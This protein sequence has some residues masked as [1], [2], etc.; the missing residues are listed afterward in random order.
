MPFCQLFNKLSRFITEPQLRQ[1][2]PGCRQSTRTENLRSTAGTDLI[3][4]FVRNLRFLR[5]MQEYFA[6]VDTYTVV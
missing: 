3:N 4:F 2:T 5:I 1:R 6:I